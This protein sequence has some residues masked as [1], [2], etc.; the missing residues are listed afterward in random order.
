MLRKFHPAVKKYINPIFEKPIQSIFIY[1]QKL[2]GNF[3]MEF[4]KSLFRNY[5]QQ[6]Q[7][8]TGKKKVKILKSQL[9]Y[10]RL[11]WMF[12]GRKING[13]TN[14][15]HKRTLR[16]V[17]NDTITSFEELLVKDKTFTIHHQNI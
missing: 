14:K 2:K 13:K 8:C 15:L 11:V 3:K 12:H 7:K 9:K 4:R 10:C 1:T 5:Q 17:Y 6:Q 16:I